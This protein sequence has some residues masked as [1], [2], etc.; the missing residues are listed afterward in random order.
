MGWDR[1]YPILDR[2]EDEIINFNL[3]GI[4]Y[5]YENMLGVGVRD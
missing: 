5:G 3:S 1:E 2:Y 4:G